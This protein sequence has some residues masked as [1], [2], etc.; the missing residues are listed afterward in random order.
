MLLGTSSVLDNFMSP[1]Y[2]TLYDLGTRV[3]PRMLV[4]MLTAD[5]FSIFE[6]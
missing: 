3:V 5:Q 4:R 2:C 6:H 1:S